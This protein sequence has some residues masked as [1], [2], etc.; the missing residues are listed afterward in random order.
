MTQCSKNNLNDTHKKHVTKYN[1]TA[2]RVV[3]FQKM[4]FED[5]YNAVSLI[6]DR[7]NSSMTMMLNQIRWVPGRQPPIYS[8]LDRWLA[9]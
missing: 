8:K 4:S 5:W 6:Q 2:K 9:A 7:A 3:A 1:Q